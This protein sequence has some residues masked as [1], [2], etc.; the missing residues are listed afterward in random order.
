LDR[1]IK[2]EDNEKYFKSGIG[3]LEDLKVLDDYSRKHEED[4]E[5]D[6]TLSGKT[7]E[8]DT[9][10]PK[11]DVD[12]EVKASGTRKV[13]RTTDP[14]DYNFDVLYEPNFKAYY[15]LKSFDPIFDT[16]IDNVDKRTSI[17]KSE[18]N[19]NVL[20]LDGTNSTLNRRAMTFSHQEKMVTVE[21]SAFYVHRFTGFSTW[22]KLYNS[23]INSG[24]SSIPSLGYPRYNYYQREGRASVNGANSRFAILKANHSEFNYSN[25]RIKAELTFEELGYGLVGFAFN[26]Q[27]ANNFY[28]AGHNGVDNKI[29]L[30]KVS[31]GAKEVLAK[32]P[33]AR[34]IKDAGR[35]G[36]DFNI[37]T[38]EVRK[39]EGQIQVFANGRKVIS[40]NDANPLTANGFGLATYRVTNARFENISFDRYIVLENTAQD[41]FLKYG[42]ASKVLST[43]T[44]N[45]IFKADMDNRLSIS[46]VNNSWYIWYQANKILKP[47]RKD[48]YLSNNW[49]KPDSSYKHR[50]GYYINNNISA[51]NEWISAWSRDKVDRLEISFTEYGDHYEKDRTYHSDQDRWRFKVDYSIYYQNEGESTWNYYTRKKSTEDTSNYSS[52]NR[53]ITINLSGTKRRRIRVVY[54]NFTVSY[55]GKTYN[56]NNGS[57]LKIRRW[58]DRQ[59]RFWQSPSYT[60]KRIYGFTEISNSNYIDGNNSLNYSGKNYTNVLPTI[61][62]SGYPTLEDYTLCRVEIQDI[63]PVSVLEEYENYEKPLNF[64]WSSSGTLSS[65]AITDS[66]ILS[67]D[68]EIVKNLTGTLD[69]IQRVE[70][71]KIREEDPRFPGA[72]LWSGIEEVTID[73]D[74]ITSTIGD[75]KI[76]IKLINKLADPKDTNI[77]FE[78]TR[79]D[80]TNYHEIN[81]A[82]SNDNILIFPNAAAITTTIFDE[83]WPATE[84]EIED[85]TINLKAYVNGYYVQ[86]ETGKYDYSASINQTG[87]GSSRQIIVNSNRGNNVSAKI[88]FP[89]DIDFGTVEYNI[90]LKSAVYDFITVTANGDS[91]EDTTVVIG[92]NKYGYIVKETVEAQ[93]DDI[94][95]SF[96]SSSTNSSNLFTEDTINISSDIL[97]D[98]YYLKGWSDTIT[99]LGSVSLS[100]PIWSLKIPEDDMSLASVFSVP[101]GDIGSYSLLAECREQML[102]PDVVILKENEQFKAMVKMTSV[103]SWKPYIHNGYFYIT[104]AN[105]DLMPKEYYLYSMVKDE[106]IIEVVNGYEYELQD[107]PKQLSPVIAKDK[108]G[109]ELTGVMFF[110]ENYNPSL[111]SKESHDVKVEHT[112]VKLS[113]INTSEIKVDVV[114]KEGNIIY[115]SS[116]KVSPGDVVNVEYYYSGSNKKT[117]TLTVSSEL[118]IE[119]SEAFV[120]GIFTDYTNIKEDTLVVS[121]HEGNPI[122][123]KDVNKNYIEIDLTADYADQK[124]NIEYMINDSFL[125]NTFGDVPTIK[126]SNNYLDGVDISYESS[127]STSYFEEV[128]INL[129]PHI[130][131][132]NEGFLF[133]SNK[134]P[135]IG[136]MEI[137][138]FPETIYSDGLQKV[139]LKVSLFDNYGNP[140][141]NPDMTKGVSLGSNGGTIEFIDYEGNLQSEIPGED[142]SIPDKFGNVYA[143]YTYAGGE[144]LSEDLIY[145]NYGDLSASNTVRINPKRI[146]NDL[147]NSAYTNN[148]TKDEFR[149][150]ITPD[151]YVI[152]KGE[153]I[154]VNVKM[155]DKNENPITD[156]AINIEIKDTYTGGTES[157]SLTT[158]KDGLCS[159]EFVKT[160]SHTVLDTYM[161]KASADVEGSV[162]EDTT[163]ITV[164]RA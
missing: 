74:G 105:N 54:H 152:L 138:V 85:A 141:F 111:T 52:K 114:K 26:V 38:L 4:F 96:T 124:V 62:L 150:N 59:D 130:N 13:E 113:V 1:E 70:I 92:E 99:K 8:N 57:Y 23:S 66:V 102:N 101:E 14:A 61:S 140:F 119:L 159:F 162:I 18:G 136:T 7:L 10:Y 128:E 6:L 17:K 156:T 15:R 48:S 46:N 126:F 30:F 98:G 58:V 142:L 83:P 25:F 120:A 72:D 139:Y 116:S 3:D 5:V 24:E 104:D 134:K 39:I 9:F 35:F 149:I 112:P 115:L 103:M 40:Y 41:D 95:S 84:D 69:E 109:K 81:G 110:D 154:R 93:L 2:I 42:E 127:I 22:Q 132:Y 45:E 64:S 33:Y 107:F 76:E 32:S 94:V 148:E 21:T 28:F 147:D 71:P 87:T 129:N 44:F 43:Q 27:D 80:T 151:K 86:D 36:P 75:S 51:G 135:Q 20:T 155:Y 67:T 31:G 49:F 16:E 161:I 137:S 133:I 60:Q 37:L 73:D 123:V 131:D 56:R 63:T 34:R 144:G 19:K 157:K 163:N 158:D 79:T 121:D 82:L 143:V 117:D 146:K 68:F 50:K 77:E 97:E 55:W 106:E 29:T 122:T 12:Y 160:L 65:T 125:V 118:T 145:G 100:E 108:E 11:L 91:I 89:R 90:D 164:M 88:L 153:Q 78:L 47:Q 53:N